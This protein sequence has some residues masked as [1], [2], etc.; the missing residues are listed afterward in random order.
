MSMY[1][2]LM[3]CWKRVFSMISMFSWEKSVSFFPASFCTPRPNLSVIPGIS[4]LLT[5]A[6]QSSIMQRTSLFHVSSRMS[7]CLHQAS[8]LHL[9]WHQWLGHRLG[10]LWCWIVCLG[11]K[12]KSF[13][14]SWI[15]TPI[16]YFRLFIDSK[17]YSIS[18]KRFLPTVAGVMLIWIK[19]DEH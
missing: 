2:H 15:C 9:L 12:T 13:Y 5:F 7:C 16:L 11:N 6:F 18:S 19:L 1:S 14:C 3:C 17:D 10:L 8:Q 4:C